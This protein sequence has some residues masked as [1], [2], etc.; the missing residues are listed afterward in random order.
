[1]TTMQATM[2]LSLIQVPK[3]MQESAN[4]VVNHILLQ[5]IELLDTG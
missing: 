3:F 4:I 5:Q 1:M 2:E